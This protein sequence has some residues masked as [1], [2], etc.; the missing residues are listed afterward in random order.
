MVRQVKD[1]RQAVKAAKAKLA[2]AESL[3]VSRENA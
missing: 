2:D 1:A 3:A